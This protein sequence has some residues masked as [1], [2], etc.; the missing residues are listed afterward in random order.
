[1]THEYRMTTRR[2]SREWMV[3]IRRLPAFM[4]GL[5]I[6][7]VLACAAFAT[8]FAAAPVRIPPVDEAA[9]DQGFLAFRSQVLAAVAAKDRT[10]ILSILSDDL[11]NSFGGDGGAREFQEMWN[12][13]GADSEFWKEFRATLDLGGAFVSED[14]F[15]AP[16]VF[17]RWPAN[18]DVYQFVAVTGVKVPVRSGSS[19]D[20]DVMA[21]LSHEAVELPEENPD[22]AW[23]KIRLADGRSGYVASSDLRSPVGYRAIFERR[24]GRWWLTAFVAG[25]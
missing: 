19:A 5:L 10:F 23:Q 1:M 16:Y 20:A 18:L 3:A 2:T 24:N 8:A 14:R 4:R 15:V 7:L 6:P 25:D 17:A 11:L 22:A 13:S 21:T 9:K 12:F